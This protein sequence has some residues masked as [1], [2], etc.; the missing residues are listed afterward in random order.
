M[1]LSHSKGM[2]ENE[3]AGKAKPS[4]GQGETRPLSVE[5]LSPAMTVASE[6]L[7]FSVM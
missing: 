3:L 2:F 6:A 1:A 4:S 5:P 7:D